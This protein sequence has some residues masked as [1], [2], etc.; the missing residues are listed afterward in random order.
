MTT[1]EI[2]KV[3]ESVLRALNQNKI[4]AKYVEHLSLYDDYSRLKLEGHK[5]TY[6]IRHLAD[7]YELNERSVFRIIKRMSKALSF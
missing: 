4:D 3:N 7:E 6:I 1:Y 2:L 5:V